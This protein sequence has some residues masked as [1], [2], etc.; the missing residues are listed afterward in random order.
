MTLTSGSI[1]DHVIF[2]YKIVVNVSPIF[3]SNSNIG[4]SESSHGQVTTVPMIIPSKS[5]SGKVSIQVHL[6]DPSP[7]EFHVFFFSGFDKS[8]ECSSEL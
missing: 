8:F 2:R 3:S 1:T 4:I 6:V 7:S 5:V